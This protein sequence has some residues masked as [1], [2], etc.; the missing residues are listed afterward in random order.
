MTLITNKLTGK[1]NLAGKE[2]GGA[3]MPG[4]EYE[5]PQAPTH[6]IHRRVAAC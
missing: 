1:R 5:L 6:Q 2:N 3:A 4:K